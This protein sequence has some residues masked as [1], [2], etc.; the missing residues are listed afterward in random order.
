MKYQIYDKKLSKYVSEPEEWFETN[1]LCDL[2]QQTSKV[3]ERYEIVSLE[4]VMESLEK[5]TR[6][7]S[8]EELAALESLKKV[9]FGFN[10][11]HVSFINSLLG[12]KDNGLEMSGK[13]SAYLWHI[14]WYYRNQIPDENIIRI[15]RE[16]KLY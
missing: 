10:T 14:V 9:S 12:S 13:M 11:A 15:A 7:I 5:E 6:P 16:R 3:E 8:D 4:K 1:K 2:L